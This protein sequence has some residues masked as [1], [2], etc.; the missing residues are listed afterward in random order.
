M[1]IIRRDTRME[2]RHV[3]EYPYRGI[4]KATTHQIKALWESGLP[5]MD[6]ARKVGICVIKLEYFLYKYKEE[7]NASKRVP[8][9]TNPIEEAAALRRSGLRWTEVAERLRTKYDA[10]KHGRKWCA[11]TVA[12]QVWRAGLS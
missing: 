6:I 7:W 2:R 1:E 4:P 8:R 10:E 5:T 9:A 3:T 11:D 12:R